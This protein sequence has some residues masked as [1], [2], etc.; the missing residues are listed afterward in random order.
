MILFCD[1]SALIKLY[2]TEPESDSLK[3]LLQEAE[4]LAVCRIAWA[5]SFAALSRRAPEVLMMLVF[6]DFQHIV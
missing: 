5:E 2:I 6:S 1:T 3:E 4:A